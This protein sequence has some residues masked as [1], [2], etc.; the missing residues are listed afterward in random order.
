MEQVRCNTD[1]QVPA[2]MTHPIQ[3]TA[4][5]VVY[6]LLPSLLQDHRQPLLPIHRLPLPC[7]LQLPLP[8][9]RTRAYQDA[10]VPVPAPTVH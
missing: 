2:C 1:C 5:P 3:I 6:R 9:C 7:C 8:A 10:F 4:S